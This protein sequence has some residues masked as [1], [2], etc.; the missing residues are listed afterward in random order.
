MART[1]WVTWLYFVHRPAVQVCASRS[2]GHLLGILSLGPRTGDV[3]SVL[4]ENLS[5]ELAH[6]LLYVSSPQIHVADH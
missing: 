3:C 5:Q 2:P 6:E 1:C 4:E